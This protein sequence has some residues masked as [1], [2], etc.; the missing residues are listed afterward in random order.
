MTWGPVETARERIMVYGDMATGKTKGALDI[1]KRLLGSGNVMH[2]V[3][4]DD[5]W[6]RMAPRDW[7]R[8]Q[9]FPDGTIERPNVDGSLSIHHVR[10][11]EQQAKGLES[12]L[13]VAERDDWVIVDSSTKLWDAVSNW[14]VH[15]AFGQEMP[16]FM[17]QHRLD[18]IKD[19]NKKDTA[20]QDR[21]LIEW[22]YINPL[23]HSV[24]TEPL[25][26]APCHVYVTAE[27]GDMRSDGKDSKGVKKQ[28]GNVGSKP[29]T[30]KGLGFAM[31]TVL[32]ADKTSA[33][34][35]RL[36]TVKDRE[37]SRG[38]RLTFDHDPW[39][40]FFTD[41]VRGVAGWKPKKS[42]K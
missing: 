7:I 2:V 16:E 35:Y 20:G 39:T 36:T 5:S 29:R 28:Y 33:G 1:A 40:D 12:T 15:K 3:D 24:V 19:P 31:H 32:M 27:A 37:D 30:Q 10:G 17:I 4:P 21:M 13:S 38:P 18:Q 34:E 8:W 11:W 25:I 42:P 6:E 41:Y 14:Y 9:Q 23:W 26:W 22:N